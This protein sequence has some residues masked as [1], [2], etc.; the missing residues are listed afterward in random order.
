MEEE[1]FQ[2]NATASV[3]D[4][5]RTD[6]GL[7]LALLPRYSSLTLF[8]R[9]SSNVSYCHHLFFLLLNTFR[10]HSQLP[11]DSPAGENPDIL[12]LG[13]LFLVSLEPDDLI[14]HLNDFCNF[15]AQQPRLAIAAF[16]F[17]IAHENFLSNTHD[18]PGFGRR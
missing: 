18:S 2:E 13:L 14:S 16:F 5:N 11:E 17:L 1:P 3:N 8:R 6:S 12:G 10:N 15:I 7:G 9:L 4:L